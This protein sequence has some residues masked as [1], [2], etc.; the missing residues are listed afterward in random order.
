MSA[1]GRNVLTISAMIDATYPAALDAEAHRWRRCAKVSEECGEV[2]EALLGLA[3]ENPRKGVTHS[4]GD[5]RKELLDVALAALGAVA[6]LDGNQGDPV[7]ALGEHAEFV[8]T[9]LKAA[10]RAAS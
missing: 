5:V 4:V 6:H 9:R 7:A 1:L 2:T 3:G 10:I 8:V